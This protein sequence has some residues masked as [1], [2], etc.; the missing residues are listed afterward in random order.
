MP[1]GQSSAKLPVILSPSQLI[2]LSLS[3]FVTRSLGHLVTWSLGHSV[4]SYSYRQT[5][6]RTTSGSTG[7]LR[8]QQVHPVVS[9][10]SHAYIPNSFHINFFDRTIR[11]NLRNFSSFSHCPLHVIRFLQKFIKI[12]LHTIWHHAMGLAT[13][14]KIA[15]QMLNVTFSLTALPWR[16]PCQ[17]DHLPCH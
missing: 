16:L 15:M 12:H 13:E 10:E 9:T 1:S 3:H 4:N 7:L 5:N 14:L 11:I 6:G 2:N 8:R 17:F